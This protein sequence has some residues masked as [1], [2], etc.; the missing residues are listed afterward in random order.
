MGWVGCIHSEKGETQRV[1]KGGVGV[2]AVWEVWVRNA[3]E[4]LCYGRV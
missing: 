1:G 4:G 2:W 3:H